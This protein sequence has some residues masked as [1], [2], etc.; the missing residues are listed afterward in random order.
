MTQKRLY[1]YAKSKGYKVLKVTYRFNGIRLSRK[2]YDL[3]DPISKMIV[4]SFEPINYTYHPEKWLVRN[5]KWD[6]LVGK[7]HYR[8]INEALKT[9]N[10]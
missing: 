4:I 10:P 7:V 1:E 3:I 9:L 2:G 6:G 5:Y 8:T